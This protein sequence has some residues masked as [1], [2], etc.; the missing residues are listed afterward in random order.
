MDG[1][2]EWNEKIHVL[3]AEI[4]DHGQGQAQA[5]LVHDIPDHS[6][7]SLQSRNDLPESVPTENKIWE[8][9]K[10]IF[11]YNNVDGR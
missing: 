4:D 9:C 10:F 3:A 1:Q 2:N 5:E 7:T 11:C 6:D 8:D